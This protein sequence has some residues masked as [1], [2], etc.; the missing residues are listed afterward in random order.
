MT[1]NDT[2]EQ[3]ITGGI[4]N[5]IKV[6]TDLTITSKSTRNKSTTFIVAFNV[7]LNNWYYVLFM[8]AVC[9]LRKKVMVYYYYIVGREKE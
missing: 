4:D 8:Y 2:A 3:V 1:F 6:S 9:H 5:D 7:L